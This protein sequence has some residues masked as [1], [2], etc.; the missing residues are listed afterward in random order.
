M[1]SIQGTLPDP[2]VTGP[3]Q[4]QATFMCTTEA[5]GERLNPLAMLPGSTV[6]AEYVP[7][8]QPCYDHLADAYVTALHS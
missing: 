2:T 3:C 8:C 1:G 6:P 5:A 7:M 4:V